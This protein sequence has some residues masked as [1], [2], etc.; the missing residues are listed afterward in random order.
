MLFPLCIAL[1]AD[2]FD[3]AAYALFAK[4]GRILSEEG[5]HRIETAVEWPV[6][7]SYLEHYTPKEVRDMDKKSRTALLARHN[8]EVTQRELSRCREAIR[9]GS[10]WNLAERRS[11]TSPY[12]RKA[13]KPVSYT[14]L[15][16]HETPEHLV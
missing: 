15:R 3:S 4:D 9:N 12:L 10:I 13:F 16:A 5:T 6:S 1:G 14:H 11:H 8:L 2:L 7:S